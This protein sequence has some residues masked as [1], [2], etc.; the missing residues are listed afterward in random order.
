MKLPRGW[1]SMIVVIPVFLIFA[2][3]IIS[4]PISINSTHKYLDSEEVKFVT[5]W[6]MLTCQKV[7]YAEIKHRQLKYQL[8]EMKNRIDYKDGVN[9]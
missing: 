3:G 9:Q 8:Q 6:E 5:S 7:P 2:W 4:V 1:L